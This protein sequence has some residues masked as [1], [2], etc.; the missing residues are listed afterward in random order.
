MTGF[1]SRQ[2]DIAIIVSTDG[3]N[4]FNSSGKKAY[5]VIAVNL[6]LAPA[7]RYKQE[8]LLIIGLWFG[9]QAPSFPYFLKEIVGDLNNV[10][11]KI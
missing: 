6:N 5:P 8:N 3:V 7:E 1:W 4:I 2:G 9:S 10:V 11:I